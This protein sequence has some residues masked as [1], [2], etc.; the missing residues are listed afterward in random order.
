MTRPLVDALMLK[1][2]PLAVK[3]FV[4]GPPWVQG[5]RLEHSYSNR[6]VYPQCR[7]QLAASLGLI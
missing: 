7:K 1:H 3:R 4:Y 6:S 2:R 5:G